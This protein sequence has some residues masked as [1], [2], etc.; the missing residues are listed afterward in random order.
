VIRSLYDCGG[1]FTFTPACALGDATAA[2]PD[3]MVARVVNPELTRSYTLA[4]AAD[5]EVD[6][7]MQVVMEALIA[8][9][10]ELVVPGKWEAAV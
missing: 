9:V 3:W 10:L 1:G 5:R 2:G 6:G 7:V 8:V 4:A